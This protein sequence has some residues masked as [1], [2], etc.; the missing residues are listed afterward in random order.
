MKRPWRKLKSRIIHKNPYYFISVHDVIRPDGRLGKY[1]VINAHKSVIIIAE[2]KNEEIFLVGQTRY[3]IGSIY[4]WELPGG[5]IEK[6]S[7]TLNSAKKELKE[8]AGLLAKKW[9]NLGYFYPAPGL[10]SEKCY[11]FLASDLLSISAKPEGTED[12]TIKKFK[13]NQV[14]SMIKKNKIFDGFAITPI[15]KYLI[16]KNLIKL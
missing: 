7:T 1:Y 16:Y 11:V 2:N 5:S 4:S 9:V 13:L 10:N 12:I 3:P 14:I 15:N 6:G 8:E